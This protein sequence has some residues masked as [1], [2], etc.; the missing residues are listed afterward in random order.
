MERLILGLDRHHC[1]KWRGGIGRRDNQLFAAAGRCQS[2]RQ[3]NLFNRFIDGQ[4]IDLCVDNPGYVVVQHQIQVGVGGQQSQHF[5]NISLDEFLI[6]QVVLVVV[7]ASDL[8]RSSLRD[9]DQFQW[10]DLFLRRLAES[11]NRM[12]FFDDHGA[13]VINHHA[14]N[15]DRVIV[16]VSDHFRIAASGRVGLIQ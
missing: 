2:Q 8:R 7:D 1:E 6:D 16:N 13:A 5:A 11:I 3:Q 15:D 14:V 4:I 10:N 12:F 9:R